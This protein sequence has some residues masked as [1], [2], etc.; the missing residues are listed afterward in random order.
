MMWAQV[1]VGRL[2]AHDCEE[3]G[4]VASFW[5]LT[6]CN[7]TRRVHKKTYFNRIHHFS[8]FSHQ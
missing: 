4:V 8:A 7:I 2:R 1:G 5:P 3:G 6:V